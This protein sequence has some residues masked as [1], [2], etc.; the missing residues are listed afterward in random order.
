[1]C[2]LPYV[3]VTDLDNFRPSTYIDTYIRNG[4]VAKI[5]LNCLVSNFYSTVKRVN[6]GKEKSKNLDTFRP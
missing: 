1:M 6:L 4:V 3:V 5:R 2:R